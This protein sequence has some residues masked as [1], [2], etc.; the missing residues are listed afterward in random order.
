LIGTLAAAN[1]ELLRNDVL[2]NVLGFLTMW[3]IMLFTYRSFAAGFYLLAP[4]LL[5]NLIV[6]AYMAGRNIG[7]NIHTLPLVTVGLG[8]G[9]DYGL[10]IVSRTLEEIR[11]LGDLR[12]AVREALTTSGKAVTFTALSMTLSTALW[13]LSN[14][15]FNAEMGLLLAMWMAISYLGSVT[16]LPA[17][18]VL[19]PPRFMTRELERARSTEEAKG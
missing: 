14:I 1:E 5:A 19:L 9:I 10:Y 2:M 13:S 6:N 17:L 3:T 12:A 4:L 11:R 8:F 7:I 16:L 18:L 15:R